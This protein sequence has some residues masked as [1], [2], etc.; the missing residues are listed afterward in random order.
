MSMEVVDC[1][2]NIRHPG[3]LMVGMRRRHRSR[4]SYYVFRRSRSS[5]EEMRWQHCGEQYVGGHVGPS[6][7]H[8][9]MEEMAVLSVPFSQWEALKLLPFGERSSLPICMK[10][11]LRNLLFQQDQG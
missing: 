10:D 4:T 7:H 1:Y 8:W 6:R 5:G 2:S 3:I 9:T 11:T